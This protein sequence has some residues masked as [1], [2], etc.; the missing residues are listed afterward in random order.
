M[1]IVVLLEDLCVRQEVHLG[2]TFFCG[3]R[4]LDGGCLK[5]IDHFNRSVLHDTARKLGV[6]DLTVATNGKAQPDRQ[7][8]HARHTHAVQAT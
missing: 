2:A 7:A 5:A 3:P 6:V 8:V 4:D 1:E